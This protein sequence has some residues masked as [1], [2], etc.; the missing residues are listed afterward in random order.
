M[1]VRVY[2]CLREH[3]PQTAMELTE[4]LRAP[5]Q[6]STSFHKR[7]SEL[8]RGGSVARLEPRQCG[9]TGMMADVWK[10]TDVHPERV[11]PVPADPTRL[12][13]GEVSACLRDLRAATRLLGAKTPRTLYALENR[14]ATLVKKG[15]SL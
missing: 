7:L 10:A 4:R 8:E 5:G 14:L 11:V 3:G 9:V 15:R 2:A 6:V 13:S 1:Q 12:S